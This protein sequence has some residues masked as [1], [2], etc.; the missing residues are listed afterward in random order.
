MTE[1]SLG[2]CFLY[3]KQR[4][5]ESEG[6]RCCESCHRCPLVLAPRPV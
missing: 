5:E 3:P 4:T 1:R 6:E 2:S